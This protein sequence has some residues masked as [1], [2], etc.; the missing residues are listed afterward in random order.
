[1]NDEDQIRALVQ[2]WQSATKAGDIDTVLGLM[3]EDVVFLVPGRDP[4]RKAEPEMQTFCHRF[5]APPHDA[6][7]LGQAGCTAGKPAPRTLPSTLGGKNGT[8]VECVQ[9]SR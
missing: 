8:S 6:Q 1:M 4:M 5:S 9:T 3:T 2:T 7:A